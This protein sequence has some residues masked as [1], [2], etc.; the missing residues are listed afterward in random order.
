[1][2]SPIPADPGKPEGTAEGQA[3]APSLSEISA[4]P[5]E[6]TRQLE[7]VVQAVA[8]QLL[9]HVGVGG[10]RNPIMERVTAEHITVALKAQEKKDVASA[11]QKKLET[12]VIPGA[13]LLAILLI[14]GFVLLISWLFLAYAKADKID[15]IVGLVLGFAAGSVGGFQF[16]RTSERNK[17]K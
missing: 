13:T 5:K 11:A 10:S 17:Q 16:G 12:Y 9:V 1:M 15:I 8:Q 6:L 4:N 7:P 14:L 3:P 2:S